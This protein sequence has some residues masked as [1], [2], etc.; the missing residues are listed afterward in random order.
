MYSTFEDALK[1]PRII[2]VLESCFSDIQGI[3]QHMRKEPNFRME[4][5]QMIAY[6]MR[7]LLTPEFSYDDALSFHE[8]S[9]K[10]SDFSYTPPSKKQ[11]RL[12]L[13]TLKGKVFSD[14]GFLTSGVSVKNIRGGTK[15]LSVLKNEFIESPQFDSLMIVQRPSPKIKFTVAVLPAS[16]ITSDMLNMPHGEITLRVLRDDLWSFF[17]RS[18]SFLRLNFKEPDRRVRERLI[19]EANMLKIQTLRRICAL[20]KESE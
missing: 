14:E 4:S 6:M 18:P 16:R 17:Y 20:E 5:G 8:D 11:Q 1:N 7:V 3:L 12:S 15:S 9:G 10:S 2:G 19:E 13:K